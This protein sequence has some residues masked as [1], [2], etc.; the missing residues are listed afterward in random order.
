MKKLD[1]SNF[2]KHAQSRVKK[3]ILKDQ[4]VITANDG[5][6]LFPEA[7][8]CHFADWV[9]FAWNQ[10][11]LLETCLNENISCCI[12]Q[13]IEVF[14]N[15]YNELGI[16]VFQR[17]QRK[18]LT[19]NPCFLNGGNTG[20]Q[21]INLAYHIGFKNIVLLGYDLTEDPQTHWHN[22]H[23]RPTNIQNFTD[24]MIPEFNT[25]T[26]CKDDYNINIVNINKRSALRC[27]DFGELQQYLK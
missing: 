11:K 23:R 4:N 15:L 22:N 21:I 24:F 14:A 2:I 20:H 12:H 17:E 18:S 26:N 25:L 3:N 1:P 6:L 7:L 10:Q 8:A 9:W 27:F 19:K 13:D 16:T 5:Y